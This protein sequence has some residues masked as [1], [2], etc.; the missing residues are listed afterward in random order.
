MNFCIKKGLALFKGQTY[1]FLQIQQTSAI[2]HGCKYAC[3]NAM[4]S[5]NCLLA[6]HQCT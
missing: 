4:F 6:T 3:Y 5:E 1:N 2:A